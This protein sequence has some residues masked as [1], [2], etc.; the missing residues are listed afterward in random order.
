MIASEK[1]PLLHNKC[2][3]K[4]LHVIDQVEEIITEL[5]NRAEEITQNL[6]YRVKER[7]YEREFKRHGEDERVQ[8]QTR[9]VQLE[10]KRK[11]RKYL[12]KE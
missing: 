6:T 4:K 5:E 11:E 2:V 1:L 7:K 12:N 3:P 8:Y 9:R 10:R